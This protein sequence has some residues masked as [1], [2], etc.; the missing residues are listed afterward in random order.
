M[1]AGELSDL[2]D[3]KLVRARIQTEPYASKF[4]YLLATREL[5]K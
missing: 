5:M 3:P 1:L 2:G 4:I